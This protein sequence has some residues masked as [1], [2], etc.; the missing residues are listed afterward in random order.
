ML[1]QLKRHA[2]TDSHVYDVRSREC[3]L[4]VFSQANVICFHYCWNVA[5][6]MYVHATCY[7]F[8]I[9]LS[10]VT[11]ISLTCYWAIK[12]CCTVGTLIHGIQSRSIRERP[13]GAW[14]GQSTSNG[15][16][17]SFIIG[18]KGCYIGTSFTV[19]S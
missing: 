14:G 4:L 16:V 18:H 11:H 12:T 6:N 19:V 13:P 10:L 9:H 17:A 15:A 7:S 2:T 1:Y 3:G 8:V 5:T